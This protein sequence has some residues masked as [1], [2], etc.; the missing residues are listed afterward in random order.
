M[1]RAGQKTLYPEVDP[2]SVDTGL[3]EEDVDPREAR[4]W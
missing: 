1:V 4:Y 3:L 2:E